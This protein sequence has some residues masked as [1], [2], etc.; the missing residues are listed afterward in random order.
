MTGNSPPLGVVKDSG[1][2]IILYVRVA[3]GLLAWWPGLTPT[4]P[5]YQEKSTCRADEA[6]RKLKAHQSKH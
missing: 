1:G 3:A 5:V 2:P 4:G 6:E